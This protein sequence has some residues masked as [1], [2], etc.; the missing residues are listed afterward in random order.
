[1]LAL[2]ICRVLMAVLLLQQAAPFNGALSETLSPDPLASKPHTE[3]RAVLQQLRSTAPE[4]RAQPPSATSEDRTAVFRSDVRMVNLS[5]AVH[6]ADG[7]PLEGLREDDFEVSEDGQPQQ[8][9]VL[10]S[11]DAPFRL[12]LML[13]L[14]GS[15]RNDRPVMKEAARQF[16]EIAQPE[17]EIAVYA[18]ANDAFQVISRF[19]TDRRA[20]SGLIEAIPELEGGSPIYDAL[21]LAY[22]EELRYLP[23]TRNAIIVITDGVDDRIYGRGAASQVSFPNL[24]RAARGWNTLIYPIFL[25]PFTVV[26]PPSWAVRARRQM[27][28]LAEATGGRLFV[29]RSI[30]DLDGVYPLVAEE[31]RGVYGIGYYP[32]NKNL[33]GSWR[34]VEVQV[35]RPG[36]IAL[37][38]AGYYAR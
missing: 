21:V 8:I 23:D 32:M 12:V 24:R 2:S 10:S 16:I 15:T 7:H 13:D 37:T 5:V 29:S 36:A 1:M 25:D 6:G 4:R 14:S 30:R 33:D 35:K 19:T 18:L 9:V 31:L 38:R 28:E 26:P 17:D 22:A 27:R 20:L 11:G 3:A 34:H